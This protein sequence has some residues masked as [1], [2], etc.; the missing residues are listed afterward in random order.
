MMSLHQSGSA[1]TRRASHKPN[2]FEIHMFMAG[3]QI[4][5]LSISQDFTCLSLARIFFASLV[6]EVAP[7]SYPSHHCPFPFSSAHPPYQLLPSSASRLDL[8]SFP[9]GSSDILVHDPCY[10]SYVVRDNRGEVVVSFFG[11]GVSFWQFEFVLACVDLIC[12]DCDIW[13]L[14]VDAWM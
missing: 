8:A 6:E 10:C 13:N 3:C 4:L 2:G 1:S 14:V 11:R 9:F 12:Q 7:F 5:T